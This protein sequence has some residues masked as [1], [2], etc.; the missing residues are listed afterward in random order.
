MIGE[1]SPF[2]SKPLRGK[3]PT[4]HGTYSMFGARLGHGLSPR[5]SCD[6][7]ADI[8]DL[9]VGG[10]FIQFLNGSFHEF[11]GDGASGVLFHFGM[12]AAF[13]DCVEKHDESI[14]GLLGKVIGILPA[15]V[16]GL[17]PHMGEI[18]QGIHEITE[19]VDRFFHVHLQ[20][21]RHK[22]F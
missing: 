18:A 15:H 5:L 22:I 17:E 9:I 14:Q 12:C 13:L 4:A 16:E 3:L 21:I 8:A 11:I 6:L 10:D 19:F 1:K 2:H 7:V 20:N